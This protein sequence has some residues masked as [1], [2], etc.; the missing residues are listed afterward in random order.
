MPGSQT[1]SL[2]G[3]SEPEVARFLERSGFHPFAPLVTAVYQATEGNPFFMTEVVRLLAQEEYQAAIHSPQSAMAIP[4]GVRAAVERRLQ[5][6]SAE[7]QQVLTLAAVMGREVDVAALEA[8]GAMLHLAPTGERLLEVL[9][10]AVAA[11]II[12]AVPPAGGRYSFTHALIRETLY[13][14]LSP[15]R[16]VRFHRQIGA[17]L[18]SL[19]GTTSEPHPSTRA[20]QA[21]AELA[22]HF[23]QAAHGGSEVDKAVSYATQAGARAM[24]ML[25]YEEAASQYER[26]LQAHSLQASLDEWQAGEL[27]LA[28]GEAHHKAGAVTQAQEVFWRAAELARRLRAREAMPHAAILLARAAV[29]FGGDWSGRFGI[30]DRRLVELLESALDA[31]EASDSVVRVRVM[32]QLAMALFTLHH[33]ERGV[34]L[35]QQAVEMARR[36]N[37]RTALAV[38]LHSRHWLLWAHGSMEERLAV[39]SEI[40]CLADAEGDHELVFHGRVWRLID[41]LE[42][43]EMTV[44][45]EEL[46]A[47]TQL[48]VALRQPFYQWWVA[49][50]QAMRPR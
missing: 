3:L 46:A 11:R 28:L 18:E 12:A 30:C 35:S 43:G 13:E 19:Y 31:L 38:A 27:L 26:A 32:S 20:G 42:S 22:Y 40:V 39:A 41:L 50:F 29:G 36:L 48:T 5:A 33:Q 2:R 15:A 16:R 23:F 49:V 24:A 25:A 6:L 10:E 21:L 45:N 47:F 8:A 1:L 34:V 44:L 9:E 17:V 7:C 37:D 4:Q 14:E